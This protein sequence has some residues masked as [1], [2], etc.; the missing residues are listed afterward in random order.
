[1]SEHG[2]GNWSREV[3]V[4]DGSVQ[5]SPPPAQS[6]QLMHRFTLCVVHATI[7]NECLYA[8]PPAPPPAP[9]PTPPPAPPLVAI[10]APAV[11][12]SVVL[13]CVLVHVVV[14]AV[15]SSAKV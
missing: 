15:Y 7:T 3:V 9:P 4:Y 6:S 1:M 11:V 2:N 5:L 12:G 10:L 8:L 14:L 13:V